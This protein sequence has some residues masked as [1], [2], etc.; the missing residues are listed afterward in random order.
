MQKLYLFSNTPSSGK[1]FV[2]IGIVGHFIAEGY[3]VAY[4]KL[5]GSSTDRLKEEKIDTDAYFI[6]KTLGLHQSAAT[7]S[8]FLLDEEHLEKLLSSGD[9]ILSSIQS[10]L[11]KLSKDKKLCVINGVNNFTQGAFLGLNPSNLVPLIDAYSIII[12]SGI[13]SSSMDDIYKA[14][15]LL[16]ERLLGVIFTNLSKKEMDTAQ[17]VIIP[18]LNKNKIK[19]LAKIPKDPVLSAVSVT[20]VFDTLGGYYIVEPAKVYDDE[21]V[22]DFFIGA[23]G[24]D[25]AMRYF[26]QS[27]NKAVITGGDRADIQFA[28]LET[29]VKLLILTGN[30]NPSDMIKSKAK[31]MK[32]PILV[33]KESTLE[34]AHKIFVLKQKL[35]MNHAKKIMR[36]Q[37]LV[38]HELNFDAIAEQMGL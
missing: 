11:D 23:M 28:A 19:C 34:I 18:Y 36:A 4:M 13:S 7:L 32:V 29:G 35:K 31:A 5:P 9:E 1:T 38:G 22:E 21:L 17:K 25:S 2:S 26:R 27:P 14:Q 24:V 6:N 20:D 15:S 37:K 12:C 33:V 30:L 16:G 10:V 3:D 8:P